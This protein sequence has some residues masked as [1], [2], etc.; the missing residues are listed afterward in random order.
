LEFQ[1]LSAAVAEVVVLSHAVLLTAVVDKVDT[2]LWV[3]EQMAQQTAAVAAVAVLM[4][5]TSTVTTAV[6]EL[7]SLGGQHESLG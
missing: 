1:V 6:L 3:L 7:L 2:A 5:L 4:F